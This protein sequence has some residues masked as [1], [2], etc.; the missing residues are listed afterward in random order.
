MGGLYIVY[1]II[2]KKQNKTFTQF[3]TRTTSFEED[4]EEEQVEEIA[5]ILG[6]DMSQKSDVFSQKTDPLAEAQEKTD[7]VEK[8]NKT[9]TQDAAEKPAEEVPDWLKGNF[10]PEVS[11]DAQENKNSSAKTQEISKTQEKSDKKL[12]TKSQKNTNT[13]D[14]QG[15]SGKKPEIKTQENIQA[16]EDKKSQTTKNIPQKQEQVV[17][18][19]KQP[20][21]EETFDLE[22]DTKLQEETN[23]PDWL[24]GSFASDDSS[25][26]TPKSD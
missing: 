16:Q 2:G 15:K 13:Q 25:Q 9:E 18:N 11:S 20:A 26:K 10:A 21:Q 7:T 6:E 22:K 12:E 4:P 17:E 1:L 19:K 5:D 23:V 3:I 8:Q 14:T 24:K